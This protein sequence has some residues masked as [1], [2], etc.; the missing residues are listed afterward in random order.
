MSIPSL[1]QQMINEALDYHM[2]MNHATFDRERRQVQV[3]GQQTLE[4]NISDVIIEATIRERISRIMTAIQKLMQST[5][6]ISP[7]TGSGKFEGGAPRREQ[8]QRR[9]LDIL[10]QTRERRQAQQEQQRRYAGGSPEDIRA[11]LE[12]DILRLT[13]ETAT[14]INQ[15]EG[16]RLTI[17]RLMQEKNRRIEE[18]RE[19]AQKAIEE[20]RRNA[21]EGE[22]KEGERAPPQTFEDLSSYMNDFDVN[23]FDIEFPGY[24]EKPA[25]AM[26]YLYSTLPV[27]QNM[28]GV[29]ADYREDIEEENQYGLP[30]LD[31]LPPRGSNQGLLFAAQPPVPRPVAPGEEEAKANEPGFFQRFNLDELDRVMEDMQRNPLGLP[32]F[33]GAP[34]GDGAPPGGDGE[35]A[36]FGNAKTAPSAGD[37]VKSRKYI[38]EAIASVLTEYNSL[39]DYL[40]LKNREK[41][42]SQR[43]ISNI[44]SLVKQLID[45]LTSAIGGASRIISDSESANEYAEYTRLYNVLSAMISNIQVGFPF[46]KVSVSLLNERVPLKEEYIT[47]PDFDPFSVENVEY[48]E[49]IEN[50]LKKELKYI[51]KMPQH[52]P[53][54]K[55]AKKMVMN[56]LQIQLD[57][58]YS[59]GY[60]PSRVIINGITKVFRNRPANFDQQIQQNFRG[61]VQR[62]VVR[63]HG[64]PKKGGH[65]HK[66]EQFDDQEILEPYLTKHLRPSKYRQNVPAIES[67][68]EESSG[69]EGSGSD[70]EVNDM[71]LGKGKKPKGRKAR[72][73]KEDLKVLSKMPVVEA[74]VLIEK[75]RGSAKPKKGLKPVHKP[76]LAN[77]QADKDLWFM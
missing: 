38:S 10:R 16:D 44:D 54:E 12:R 64:K 21:G 40:D 56:Q 24:L 26:Q 11:A 50:T 25:R 71:R 33:P 4:K 1:R 48:F 60:R 62:R 52:T 35:P 41:T 7:T 32:R 59:V 74:S 17:R 18:L 2:N 69:D 19:E 29:P 37:A 75:K 45:P 55:N 77:D 49:N 22:E 42:F 46:Q 72:K 15:N 53:L 30:P 61:L 6:Y 73:Q 3:M 51:D 47:R 5:E 76:V 68:S 31:E 14:A 70:M 58:L 57:K 8:S 28:F 65:I 20:L 43:D 39:C 67:S 9:T 66:T 63:G 23:E 27:I 36:P 13:E 34:P